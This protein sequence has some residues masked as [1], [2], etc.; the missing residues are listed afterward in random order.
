MRGA[1]TDFLFESFFRRNY[2]I[3]PSPIFFE[4]EVF[5]NIENWIRFPGQNRN[6]PLSCSLRSPASPFTSY[7]HESWTMAKHDKNTTWG[8]IRNL[9]NSLGTWWEPLLLPFPPKTDFLTVLLCVF[10]ASPTTAPTRV[11]W[12]R[13]QEKLKF[14]DPACLTRHGRQSQSP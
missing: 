10:P 8:A 3:G 9:E 5:P 1:P 13:L 6:I 14:H 7:I 12:R 4:H 2:L 11:A